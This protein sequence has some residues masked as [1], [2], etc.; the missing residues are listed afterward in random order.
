MIK[1]FADDKQ[2]V[3]VVNNEE[4]S[5]K[6]KENINGLVG[7]TEVLLLSIWGLSV[8]SELG[9]EHVF[10][11]TRVGHADSGPSPLQPIKVVECLDAGDVGPVKDAGVYTPFFVVDLQ[12]L[13]QAALV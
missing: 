2:I 1:M 5:R 11:E 4:N 9:I 6:L 10:G 8:V 7:I 3:R 12:D 13:A